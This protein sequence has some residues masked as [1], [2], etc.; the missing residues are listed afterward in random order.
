MVPIP[1]REYHQM[2]GRA[3]RPHLDP[4]GEAVLIAK[5]EEDV[6]ALYEFYIDAPPEDVN[7]QIASEAALST[8]AL[9]HRIRFCPFPG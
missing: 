9:A 2:A 8:H 3:G 7:S 4:Y 6:C 1:A 5:E